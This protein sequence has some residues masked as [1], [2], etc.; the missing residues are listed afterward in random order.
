[1]NNRVYLRNL[2]FSINQQSLRLQLH[3][4]HLDTGLEKIVILRRGTSLTSTFCS[5]FLIYGTE[6]Q[7]LQ[8]V[9]ALDGQVVLELGPY[10]LA[11]S[12][13]DSR[14]AATGVAATASVPQAVPIAAPCAFVAAPCAFVAAPGTFVAAPAPAPQAFPQAPWNA[15]VPGP[16][17]PRLFIAGA[18]C[19][20]GA[21]AYS[22]PPP[23]PAHPPKPPPFPPP[24]PLLP[25]T[26]PLLP[27]PA[28]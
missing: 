23:E 14:P 17:G 24:H 28:S 21:K 25:P 15:P 26:T 13:A 5:C 22:G 12:L 10:Q 2:Y 11:A 6:Q 19:K 8:T 27:P 1:M 7:A 18:T 3:G 16:L 20:S 4:M 9:A